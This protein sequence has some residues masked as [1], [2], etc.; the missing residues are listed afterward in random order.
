MTQVGFKLT[1]QGCLA[2]LFLPLQTPKHWEVL[3][4][5]LF[6][7]FKDI[8]WVQIRAGQKPRFVELPPGFSGQLRRA[9]LVESSETRLIFLVCREAHLEFFTSPG[10]TNRHLVSLLPT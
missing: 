10:D 4:G 2:L 8:A 3:F 5:F 9:I 1:T 7:F 6:G